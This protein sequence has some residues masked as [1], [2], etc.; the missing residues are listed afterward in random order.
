M[1]ARPDGLTV[2]AS[3]TRSS[4]RMLCRAALGLDPRVVVVK[5]IPGYHDSSLVGLVGGSSPPRALVLELYG[6]GNG[7]RHMASAWLCSSQGRAAHPLVGLLSSA[8]QPAQPVV[9]PFSHPVPAFGL[10]LLL[11]SLC[12]ALHFSA[13]HGSTEHEAGAD[14]AAGVVLG[15][16]HR[17]G[18]LLAVQERGGGI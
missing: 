12:F 11:C 8:G 7:E 3:G 9:M 16:G 17:G 14:R 5:L 18:G 10:L 4:P 15:Q 1:D 6:T 13:R 2:A